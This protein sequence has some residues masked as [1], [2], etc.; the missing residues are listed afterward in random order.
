[1]NVLRATDLRADYGGIEVLHGID[2]RVDAGEVVV[3]LGPNGAGK[4]TALLALS[5]ALPSSGS[6]E[7]LGAPAVGSVD[8]RAR[9]GVALLPEERGIIRALTVEE[10]LRLAGVPTEAAY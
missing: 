3:V 8:Q 4:T 1:M 5:G 10:N 2:L 6:L 7:L 9:L